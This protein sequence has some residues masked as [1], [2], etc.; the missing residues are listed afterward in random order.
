MKII[1]FNF[2]KI[3]AEKIKDIDGKFEVKTNLEINKIEKHSIDL[4]SKNVANAA[5]VD[6]KF[7]VLYEPGF[8][9]IFLEGF[10]LLMLEDAPFKELIKKWKNKKIQDEIR[11]PLFNFIMS[12]SNIKSLQF[13]EEFALPTHIPMPRLTAEPNKNSNYHG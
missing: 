10:V 5:K 3:S 6:F 9:K 4:V 2:S 8:A 12:K 1:G 7:S 11:L 13:E